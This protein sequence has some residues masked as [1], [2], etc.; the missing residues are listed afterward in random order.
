MLVVAA[1]VDCCSAN[2]SSGIAVGLVLPIGMDSIMV[3]VVPAH[4]MHSVEL[5]RLNSSHHL[6]LFA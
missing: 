3:A 6:H 5:R 2:E 4:T 1:A